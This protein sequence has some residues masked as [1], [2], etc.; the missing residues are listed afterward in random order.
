MTKA[1]DPFEE[2]L[3]K[4]KVEMLEDQ[5][6]KE[7]KPGSEE[8][9][10][11]GTY[12]DDWSPKEPDE[13][14][15]QEERLAEEMND[16]FEK[17]ADAGAELFGR[18][19]EIDEERV[20]EIRD[21]IEDV[22]EEDLSAP[23]VA[24]G[25]DETFVDFFKSVQTSFD[26]DVAT[27]RAEQQAQAWTQI[28]A[29]PPAQ[30]AEQQAEQPAETPAAEGAF[31]DEPL[32]AEFPVPEDAAPAPAE[33]PAAAA[34]APAEPPIASETDAIAEVMEALE[35]I[36]SA[37]PEPVAEAPS[38]DAAPDQPPVA[39]EAINLAEIL[40]SLK[41][42]EDPARH[43]EVLSRLVIKLVERSDLAE[44]EI[45]EVLIKSGMGF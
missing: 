37:A 8:S 9:G 6:R 26:P 4:K 1:V 29:E 10:S 32:T 15:E 30:P 5:F 3:R 24:E 12:K 36:E 14:P 2:F 33:I 31:E 21:A 28:P 17:G 41:E 40:T 20:D 27:L 44:G 45:V 23:E 7:G 11:E 25:A 43:I 19:Q 13:S 22:F 38:E 39:E 34:A 42:G 35:S 18:A 16:F